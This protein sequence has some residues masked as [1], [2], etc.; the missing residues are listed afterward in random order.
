MNISK[1]LVPGATLLIEV[2]APADLI[3][4]Q[5]LIVERELVTFVGPSSQTSGVVGYGVPVLA[6][7]RADGSL[8]VQLSV[9]RKGRVLKRPQSARSSD[10]PSR[11]IQELDI[12]V[13]DEDYVLS[14][15]QG[16]NFAALQEY[17]LKWVHATFPMGADRQTCLELRH[18]VFSV[19]GTVA[20]HVISDT[21]LQQLVLEKDT[22]AEK[23]EILLSYLRSKTAMES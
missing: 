13:V 7:I 23:I 14:E 11:L 5:R 6:G 12:E 4:I 3:E 8:L 21:D 19:I 17:Y 9:F 16:M 10:D 15:H 1:V 20:T 22:A 18:A 2:K